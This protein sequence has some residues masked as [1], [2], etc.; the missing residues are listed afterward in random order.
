MLEGSPA[1]G[2]W[3]RKLDFHVLQSRGFVARAHEPW[4]H[5][6][7]T[8]RMHCRSMPRLPNQSQKVRMCVAAAS[9]WLRVCEH[10]PRTFWAGRSTWTS[11]YRARAPAVRA[12]E[13]NLVAP[14]CEVGVILTSRG[15]GSQPDARRVGGGE[16]ARAP[17][18]PHAPNSEKR[19]NYGEEGCVQKLRRR[20]LN[21]GLPRDRRKY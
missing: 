21:P 11:H 19:P 14:P 20:E 4:P 15:A 6:L 2:I 8:H 7:H 10:A 18:R 1:I 5:A 9:V 12:H 16:P 3:V 13:A 17:R